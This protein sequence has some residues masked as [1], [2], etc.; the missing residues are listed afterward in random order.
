MRV[1]TEHVEARA[2]G[3]QQYGV[4]GPGHLRGRAHRLGHAG[5]ALSGAD[6]A[7]H[8][9]DHRRVA[10][11]EH[12]VAHLAAEGRAQRREVLRLAVTAGDHDQRSG[13]T[14]DRGEGRADIGALGVIYVADPGHVGHPLRTVRQPRESR[15]FI[16]HG[17]QW[18]TDRLAQGE[19]G[20]RVCRVVQSGQSHRVDRNQRLAAADQPRL[21]RIGGHGVVGTGRVQ[22]REAHHPRRLVRHGGDQRVIQIDHGGVATGKDAGLGGCVLAHRR[23]TVHVVGRDVQDRGGPQIQRRGGLELVTGKLQ[24]IEFRGLRV[25]LRRLQQVQRW[26]TEIA[27]D[28]H[29]HAGARRHPPYERRHGALAVGAGHTH[30]GPIG[31]HREQLDVAHDGDTATLRLGEEWIGKRD[32]GGCHHAHRFVEQARIQGTEAHGDVRCQPRKLGATRRIFAAVGDADAPAM[33]QQVAR[34]GQPRDP[35]AHDYRGS[36]LVARLAHRTF[37]VAR[38]NSTSSRERIQKR[39]IT[40]G[41]AQP[42]S[43]KW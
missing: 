42:L 12:H 1:V 38:P 5:A 4:T 39:T 43:S 20:E 37:R 10:A 16:E 31:S 24:H 21:A 29:P 11:D 15:E 40:F 13:H 6:I 7:Q 28:A 34:A 26:L 19:C 35:Q 2:G 17:L 32:A 33:S 27:A 25:R 18:Q 8:L 36:R 3:R 22:Q 23:V 14:R 9:L 30:D 41:S